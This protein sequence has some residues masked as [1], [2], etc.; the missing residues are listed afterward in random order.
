MQL[1]LALLGVLATFILTQLAEGTVP[2]RRLLDTKAEDWSKARM[3]R[4]NTCY[5]ESVTPLNTDSPSF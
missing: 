5:R 3:W 1:L 2:G 4:E